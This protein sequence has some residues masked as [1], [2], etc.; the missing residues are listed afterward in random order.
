MNIK[1][2]NI[3][4]EKMN[5]FFKLYFAFVSMMILNFFLTANPF[6]ALH[7]GKAGLNHNIISDKFFIVPAYLVLISL[8]IL[9]IYVNKIVLDY[10][11]TVA[12][13]ILLVS[14][15]YTQG[16]FTNLVTYVYNFLTFSLVASLALT[17]YKLDDNDEIINLKKIA[18]ILTVFLFAGILLA[19]MFP[20]RY[21]FLPFEFSR[22]SRGEVTLW[23]VTGIFTLYPTIAILAFRKYKIKYYIILSLIMT[24][25]VLSTSTRAHVVITL[26][27]FFIVILFNIKIIYKMI[28]ISF[29]VVFTLFFRENILVFIMGSNV[30]YS[31]D[32]TNGRLELWQYH[33]EYILRNPLFGAGA[34]FSERIGDYTGRAVSEIGAL[35]WFSENGIIF[36]S[37]LMLIIVTAAFRSVRLLL[38]GKNTTDIEMFFSLI[39]LSMFPNLIQSYGRILSLE[40]MIFW[41]S[42]FFLNAYSKNLFP[43][44]KLYK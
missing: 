19:L 16:L 20:N 12:M 25:I 39:M 4:R 30:N 14:G 34:S 33:W 6:S 5:T 10:K 23:N 27:P 40:D 26:L 28:L 31:S 13:C 11:F 35:A 36:G 7:S 42:V 24:L 38:K 44:I 17:M 29:F 3:L 21:G 41:F 1:N 15:L 2:D 22:Q 32:I 9:L 37:I 8:I 18:N 43:N